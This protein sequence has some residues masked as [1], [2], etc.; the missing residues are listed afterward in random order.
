MA[1][2]KYPWESNY[3]ENIKWHNPIP[4]KSLYSILDESAKNYPDKICIDYYG[5]EYTYSTI[6]ELA[7]KFAKGLQQNGVKKGDKVGL[8]LPNC[9]LFIIAYYGILKCGAVVVNY[10][11]LY[12]VNELVNQVKGSDTS[13]MV[14]LNLK[15]FFEKIS[16]L[17]QMTSLKKV[18]VGDL[19]TQLPFFKKVA[20]SVLK[21]NEIVAVTSGGVHIL[22]EELLQNDGIYNKIETIPEQDI[23]VL[24]YTG[25]TTGTP[26]GGMLTHANL[27]QNTVQTGWW[28]SG[29]KEGG[30]V[31]L[32]VLPFFHVFAMTIVM[33]LSILKACKI[34]MHSRLNV[35]ALLKDISNKKITLMP[36]VPT[37]FNAINNHKKREKYDLSSLKFCISGGAPLPLEIKESFEAI[38]KCTLIEGYGLTEASPVA[39]AN[40]LFGENRKGSIGIPLPNTIV[41]IRDINGERELLGVGQ[42]G[43]ICIKGPQIMQGYL[44]NEEETKNV[45]KSGFLHTG[46][47]GYMDSDGYIY[48]VDRLK[49]MI[50][51]SGFNVY[52][53]EIEEE[54][55]KHESVEEAC[56]VGVADIAKGQLI[57]AFIKLKA[58]QSVSEEQMKEFLKGKLAKYKQPSYIEFIDTMPKSII[59]KILKRELLKGEKGDKN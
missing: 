15:L 41:E 40:P 16:S 17:L 12:T 47:M 27:Y 19:K 10:N 33:N 2:K 43:E 35:D 45:L 26:K 25:G 28:F 36:G 48:I 6:H 7:N 37:L 3:P 8:F 23:A 1:T 57:K 20:F 11:P 53:R 4:N 56:V 55:Y 30:E 31:M 34:V 5:K 49:E 46:D 42:I 32:G 38:A 9:P 54:I 44:G 13:F 21:R 29:L 52:P 22:A 39:T 50:I 58:G 59:G 24:Q 14:T 18:I 51:T